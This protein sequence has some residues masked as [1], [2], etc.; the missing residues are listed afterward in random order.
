MVRLFHLG[1]LKKSLAAALNYQIGAAQSSLAG[2][3]A[4]S[5]PGVLRAR[6][7][8]I[9]TRLTFFKLYIRLWLRQKK[10]KSKRSS[11]KNLGHETVLIPSL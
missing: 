3:H 1:R 5:L 4:L 11:L 9:G 2:Y 7:G 8:V 6:F 10:H